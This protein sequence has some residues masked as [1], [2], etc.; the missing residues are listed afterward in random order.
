MKD[1]ILDRGLSI[2]VAGGASI[3]GVGGLTANEF[4]AF[5]GLALAAASFALNWYYRHKTY[6][7]QKN[8]AEKT[9]GPSDG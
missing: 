5:T 2:G 4:A 8:M 1:V 3:A 7:H 9:A 6:L